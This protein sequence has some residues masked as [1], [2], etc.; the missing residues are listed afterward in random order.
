MSVF[1]NIIN[2]C[3]EADKNGQDVSHYI[4]TFADM[5]DD[6]L[7]IPEFMNLPD[8]ILF[9]AIKTTKYLF[10]KMEML[11]LVECVAYKYKRATSQ[12]IQPIRD[13]PD[14]IPGEYIISTIEGYSNWGENPKAEIP[15]PVNSP[16]VPPL[17]Y[18]L[19]KSRQER[20]ISRIIEAQQEQVTKLTEERQEAIK[21][22]KEVDAEKQKC[23]EELTEN[24]KEL[25]KA[26]KDVMSQ[27]SD[28]L[29]QLTED[30]AEAQRRI[31]QNITVDDHKNQMKET[32][33]HNKEILADLNQRIQVEVDNLTDLMA[34]VNGG[35]TSQQLREEKEQ[36]E[37]EELERKLH[38]VPE[39]LKTKFTLPAKP[40]TIRNIYG[41]KETKLP[42]NIKTIFDAIALEDRDAIHSMLEKRPNLAKELGANRTTP[43]HE[44]AKHR[45]ADIAELL[46]QNGADVNAKDISMMTPLHYAGITGDEKIVAVLIENH[47]VQS[48]KNKKGQNVLDLVQD[49]D[50][51]RQKLFTFCEKGEKKGIVDIL[52]KWPDMVSYNFGKGTG[53]MHLAAAYGQPE[54]M[55]L[56]QQWGAHIET[57]DDTQ[58]TPLHYACR[59]RKDNAIQYLIDHGANYHALSSMNMMPF[60]LYPEKEP[61]ITEEE[62]KEEEEEKPVEKKPEPKVVE[63]KPEEEEKKPV[64]VHPLEDV[65]D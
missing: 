17:I 64:P 41:P 46:I 15:E 18:E 48:M 59:Y 34:I 32:A 38:E 29:N 12:A 7:H 37:K 54:V 39:L 50:T 49:R 51:S 19:I 8:S 47:A 33:A 13:A 20:R 24:L 4:S 3:L 25:E 23:N 58:E 61:V 21:T 14:E 35:K 63:V 2:K 26:H 62:E 55:E 44:A 22:L 40:I 45:M 53:P 60:D 31:G 10:S 36:K 57:K 27:K 30:I 9:E 11:Y 56:L 1:V 52:K 6:F 5:M 65:I 43:L 16:E 42:K 28:K